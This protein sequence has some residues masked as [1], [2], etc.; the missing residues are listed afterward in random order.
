[1]LAFPTPAD[2]LEPVTA[3][4]PV[5]ITTN[6]PNVD[7]RG[8]AGNPIA[9][10]RLVIEGSPEKD[11]YYIQAEFSKPTGL[12][13]ILVKVP[14]MG[15]GG[16]VYVSEDGVKF[17]RSVRYEFKPRDVHGY[18]H[19]NL[20]DAPLKLKAVRLP[21][22]WSFEGTKFP[23]ISHLK[24]T[25][26]SINP[27]IISKA[28]YDQ[29]N[30][31]NDMPMPR[32]ML[33]GMR[34]PVSRDSIIDPKSIINLSALMKPDGTL[35]WNIPPGKWTIMRFGYSTTGAT[36]GWFYWSGLEC[37]KLA[38]EGIEAAW[39]GM[40]KPIV[41][42]LGKLS[43][44]VLV[45]CFIDSFEVGGQN[46]TE[47]MP[48]EFR[49][50][51]GYDLIPFLPAMTGRTVGSP[52]ISERFLW[53]LRRTIAE[54]FAKNYHRG[55]TRLCHRAGLRSMAEPY[56]APYESMLSG[57]QV[58]MPMAEFWQDGEFDTSKAISSIAHG[59]G[60]RIVPAESFTGVPGKH[61]SWKDDPYSMKAFGDLM[62]SQ[63]VNRFVFHSFIHQ[64]WLNIKPGL[65]MG[66]HG[67]N[68]NRANTWF[69]VSTGWIQYLSRCQYL[70]QQG[71][72]VADVAYFSGQG[73]PNVHRPGKPPRP[74]GDDYHSINADLLMNHAQVV[75]QRL[76][77]ESGARYAVLVLTPDDPL[78]TPELLSKIKEFV[79]SG[80]TLLGAP[81]AC[82]PSL[83]N[84][85]ECEQRMQALV[86]DLWGAFEGT[87]T[88]SHAFGKGQVIVGKTLA[89][90]LPELGVICDCSAPEGIK[91]IHQSTGTADCYFVSNQKDEARQVECVFRISGKIP[92]LFHPD[93]GRIEPAVSYTVK[94]DTVRVAMNLDPRGSD[95][96]F[97]RKKAAGG[98]REQE[99]GRVQTKPL[100]PMI[101][102]GPWKLSFPPNL[103]APES[104]VLDRLISWPEHPDEGVK[105]FSGSATYAKEIVIPAEAVG[106]GR[107]IVLDMGEVKNIARVKLNGVDFGIYWKPPFQ[108]EIT[109]AAKPGKNKLVIEVT[110]LWPNRLIGDEQLPEDTQWQPMKDPKTRNHGVGV[111]IETKAWPEWLLKGEPS[112][113]GRLTFATWKHYFKDSPLLPSGLIGPARLEFFQ[114]IRRCKA[115]DVSYN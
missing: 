8:L 20:G 3:D 39:N 72:T 50:E 6:A 31:S 33:D 22:E 48:E 43:G 38:P 56:W 71:R 85:P 110:N 88:H 1:M 107:Q 60:K 23:P 82:S 105:Y 21:F 95:F 30:N 53:D 89:E 45:D 77:L 98:E 52:A 87:P 44:K 94:G 14:L 80:L 73:A 28:V 101:V 109:A 10:S 69:E 34:R 108:A 58:D 16:Y 2:E 27:D 70:L 79:A 19:V 15:T 5:M 11:P 40:M 114:T 24:F 65:T 67:I 17:T 90:V 36:N 84:Y 55:F 96:V 49:A 81:P 18:A 25:N 106:A 83:K 62:Y 75:D 4:N 9:G 68:L 66:A 97:F 76:V 93:T 113:T 103:G 111:G 102:E 99:S 112:P 47:K 74:D 51:S 41:E 59:Y 78:M 32:R 37:D 35:E 63:G 61:G 13:S 29:P 91:F 26:R 115:N 42:R 54:L 7:V 100:E 64:P 104:V 12:E 92:E 86:R 57:A 46:W